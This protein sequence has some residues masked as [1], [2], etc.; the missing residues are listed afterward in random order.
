MVEVVIVKRENKWSTSDERGLE[1]VPLWGVT[2]SNDNPMLDFASHGKDNIFT[3]Y[4]PN[5]QFL[6]CIDLGWNCSAWGSACTPTNYQGTSFLLTPPAS[7]IEK[8][9]R[10]GRFPS[11]HYFPINNARA[12]Y[13]LRKRLRK[14]AEED[15][16]RLWF[17]VSL[18]ECL[19]LTLI[20]F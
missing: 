2:L 4:V 19:I 5:D 8:S 12:K 16:L 9:Y 10:K 3:F 7:I 14:E 1:I 15:E 13:K 18:F 20:V 17:C 6:D 11:S